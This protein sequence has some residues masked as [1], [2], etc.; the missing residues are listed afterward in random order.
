MS[1][2]VAVPP[3]SVG[4]LPPCDA[5][6]LFYCFK[7]GR[8]SDESHVLA[9]LLDDHTIEGHSRVDVV[10]HLTRVSLRCVIPPSG[11]NGAQVNRRAYSSKCARIY[12]KL[13]QF[14]PAASSLDSHTRPEEVHAPRCKYTPEAAQGSWDLLASK[15]EP[16]SSSVACAHNDT[17]PHHVRGRSTSGR[18]APARLQ[19]IN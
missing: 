19:F 5:S 13:F 7:L 4:I 2:R 8:P 11:E 17:G 9:S 12:D 3:V 6:L 15:H 18:H 16:G 14:G 10:A 1:D